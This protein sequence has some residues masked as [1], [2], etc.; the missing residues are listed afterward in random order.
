MFS[1][2]YTVRKQFKASFVLFF[3]E[4]IFLR[5]IVFPPFANL[6]LHLG[7]NV[8]GATNGHLKPSD[9]VAL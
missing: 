3:K 8:S 6:F 5:Q 9:K 7:E 2:L 4:Y 1:V